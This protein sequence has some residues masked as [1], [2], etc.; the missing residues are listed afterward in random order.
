MGK[1]ILTVIIMLISICG[2]AQKIKIDKGEIKLD[3]KTIGYIEGKK[4]VFKIYN[5]D[6][7]YS[8]I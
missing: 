5:L 7:S 2:F 6:K 3:E 4:P 8:V 1:N